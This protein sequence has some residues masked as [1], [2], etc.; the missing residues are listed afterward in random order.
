MPVFQF[1]V[2]GG[3]VA[4]WELLRRSRRTVAV[5]EVALAAAERGTAAET[6]D[7]LISLWL[8]ELG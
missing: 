3:V 7:Q 6:F 8:P 1:L 2:G 5:D 4:G